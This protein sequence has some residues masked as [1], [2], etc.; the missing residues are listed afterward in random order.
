MLF[1]GGQDSTACLA[2]ALTRFESVESV[3]FAYKQRHAAELQAR[4]RILA[5]IST[6]FAAWKQKIAADHILE[7]GGIIFTGFA[8]WKAA[9]ELPRPRMEAFEKT[10]RIR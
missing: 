9:R 4:K 6:E 1:S 3:G 5:R 7:L 2:W 10:V 8:A